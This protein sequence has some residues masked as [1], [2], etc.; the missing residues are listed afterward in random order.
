MIGEHG[1]RIVTFEKTAAGMTKPSPYLIPEP[2]SLFAFDMGANAPI[3]H[4]RA[5]ALL[6]AGLYP[7][8]RSGKIS[9]EPLPETMVGE[10]SSPTPDIIL[11]DT[12]TETT[13]VIVE[14]CQTVGQKADLKKIISLVDGE[15]YGIQEGFLYNYKT[16]Q[17]LRYQ[18]GDAGVA[19]ESSFSTVLNL[20][21]NQ[22]L[23]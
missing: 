19:T 11:F 20:N 21:L 18:L 23:H 17:W 15:S 16:Q 6:T 13:K 3:Y 9:Y 1:R 22:F 10:Y 2:D 14:V 5:I 12:A 4:Q 8:Y 7:L